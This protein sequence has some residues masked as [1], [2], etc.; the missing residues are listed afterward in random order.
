MLVAGAFLG[1]ALVLCVLAALGI[2]GVVHFRMSGSAGVERDGLDRGDR[3]PRW[4]L[5]DSVGE[6]VVSPPLKPFQL[7]AFT[8]HSL[9]SFPSLAE[10]L[11][12]LQRSAEQ[13]E[14]VVLLRG[15][16]HERTTA[17]LGFLGTWN[18]LCRV[19]FS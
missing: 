10:G 1:L 19:R 16:R 13:L 5:H 14:I 15:G 7:I 18:A 3:A 17:I 11:R 6:L 12:D 9:K 2:L 8:D 4:S